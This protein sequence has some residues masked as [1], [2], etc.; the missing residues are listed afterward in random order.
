MQARG[1]NRPI[2]LLSVFLLKA[3]RLS[4][5][6]SSSCSLAH[7][8][9]FST[10][11]FALQYSEIPSTTLFSGDFSAPYLHFAALASLTERRLMKMT[12]P[13]LIYC[14]LGDNNK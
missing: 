8:E 3:L 14:H 5:A 10:L 6:R 2:R 7:T 11:K 4:E 9:E 1:E 12:N 13:A